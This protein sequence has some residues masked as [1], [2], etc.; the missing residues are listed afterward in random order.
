MNEDT[1]RCFDFVFSFRKIL[2][3]LFVI[4]FII[5]MKEKICFLLR[6]LFSFK[7]HILSPLPE[8]FEALCFHAAYLIVV[9]FSVV[10]AF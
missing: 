9:V 10:F 4:Y 1:L 6:I 7:V 8:L 5:A 3:I 2:I